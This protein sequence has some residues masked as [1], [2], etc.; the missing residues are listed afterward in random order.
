MEMDKKQW[1]PQVRGSCIQVQRFMGFPGGSIMAN[2]GTTHH[3]YP[4]S[5]R[6]WE[7]GCLCEK[8]NWDDSIWH[9]AQCRGRHS[10]DRTPRS[11]GLA[12]QLDQWYQLEPQPQIWTLDTITA[13]QCHLAP[14]VAHAQPH[15]SFKNQCF[16]AWKVK[17]S[18]MRVLLRTSWE[19]YPPLFNIDSPNGHYLSSTR[20]SPQWVH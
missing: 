3:H 10:L 17:R 1:T 19:V 8:W 11:A 7:A 18:K 5:A 13:S 12:Q 15:S 9:V 14:S 2:C 20:L 16:L 4:G 6:R